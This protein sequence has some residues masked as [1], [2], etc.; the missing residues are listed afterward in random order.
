MRQFRVCTFLLGFAVALSSAA[1]AAP[2][3]KQAGG[4]RDKAISE[5][6]ALAKASAPLSQQLSGAAADPSS[7]AMETYKSCMRQKGYRP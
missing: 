4:G 1:S 5:C 2:A 7:G 6:V 3:K